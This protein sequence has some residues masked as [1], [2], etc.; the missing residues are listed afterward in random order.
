M[1]DIISL[2]AA[3]LTNATGWAVYQSSKQQDKSAESRQKSQTCPCDTNRALSVFID[4]V[5][6]LRNY[7]EQN[8]VPSQ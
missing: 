3:G 2:M 1:S 5:S 7:R 4:S 6:W 8:L